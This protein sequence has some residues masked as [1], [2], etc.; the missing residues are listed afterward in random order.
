MI[1][2][3]HLHVWSDDADTYPFAEGRKHS[4]GANVELLNQTMDGAGVDR[5]VIVQPVHYLYDNRYVIDCVRRFP[6]RFATVGLVDRQAPDA[7]DQLSVLVEEHGFS[8]LRL[9]LSR[10]NDPA[11]WAAPDQDAIWERAR[12]LGA[13]FQIYGP[14]DK[15]GAVEPIIARFSD[16]T[17]VLDHNGGAPP[18][19]PEPRPLFETVKSLAQY[20]N[21]YVKLTPQ[22]H[23]SEQ[24]FPHADTW[25]LY[26]RLYDAFGPQRLM[27]G[28][29]FPGVMQGLGYGPALELFS[30]H[31]DWLTADDRQAIFADVPLRVWRF[32]RV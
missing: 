25:D 3:T 8:G 31:I 23:R 9:H 16:V 10:P 7:P 1:I 19:E 26:R 17:V 13:C 30:Q 4:T 28:T 11:E 22:P 27:W 21:L 14:A 18:L 20:P 12:Q 32:G 15:L 5:A 29:N 24:D 2:D 6:Q